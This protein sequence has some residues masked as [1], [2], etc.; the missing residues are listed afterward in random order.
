MSR[1]NHNIWSWYIINPLITLWK[2][3]CDILLEVFTLP[4]SSALKRNTLGP[5]K[6]IINGSNLSRQE[7]H[8]LVERFI[9][10]KTKEAQ[11]VQVAVSKA[12]SLYQASHDSRRKEQDD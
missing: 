10:L 7:K 12:S 5:I 4:Y 3:A 8:I 9:R 6:A 2:Q 1:Q 11:Y